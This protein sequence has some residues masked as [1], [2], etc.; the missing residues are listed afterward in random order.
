[1][2]DQSVTR[3]DFERVF[4]EFSKAI[5]ES[6]PNK[7]ESDDVILAWGPAEVIDDLVNLPAAK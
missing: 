3:A 5:N 7:T 2:M 4:A 6:E 1:M